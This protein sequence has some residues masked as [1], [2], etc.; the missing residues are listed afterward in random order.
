M[1]TKKKRNLY[2]IIVI[3]FL[4]LMV[5]IFVI[6][7]A[8]FDPGKDLVTYINNLLVK[9]KKPSI[10][11]SKQAFDVSEIIPA[12]VKVKCFRL[13]DDNPLQEGS[14]FAASDSAG[15]ALIFT[16]AHVVREEGTGLLDYCLVYFPEK[17]GSYYDSVFGAGTITNF[18]GL[19]VKLDNENIYG[20]DLAVLKLNEYPADSPEASL[21]ARKADQ[22]PNV[23]KVSRKTCPSN[24]EVQ[25]GQKIFILGYPLIGG[26]NVTVTDGII[27][28]FDGQLNQFIKTS[29][30]I[31]FGN[32]GGIAVTQD[33]GCLVGIPTKISIGPAESLG[34][35]LSL[36]FIER[37]FKAIP[38]NF[39]R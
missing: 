20:I 35:V 34:Q 25:I 16:N 3:V 26:E 39:S 33:E 15:N 7:R 36:S 21:S 2:K 29:A 17:N 11:D 10:T 18:D 31:S 30:K 12:V 14:G 1:K 13:E 5:G 8:R 6:V 37:F 9:L 19:I 22:T 28:G 32:S 23:L 38:N 24:R 4:S 27:S